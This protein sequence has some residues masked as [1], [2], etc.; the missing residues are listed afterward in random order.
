MIKLFAAILVAEDVGHA[1]A[2]VFIPSSGT[3]CLLPN[4][5]ESRT[6]HSLNGFLLCGDYYDSEKG[7]SCLQFDPSSGTWART[8][9]TLLQWRAQHVSWTV[10]E[11][12]ILMGGSNT[13]GETDATS[14]SE[15]VKHDGSVEEAFNLKYPT[16]YRYKSSLNLSRFRSIYILIG[17]LA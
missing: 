10:A 16:R 1:S 6:D 15:I 9:H 5:P 8:G 2:E 12:T 13:G 17:R 3:S 11:G 7:H 4:I 14:T